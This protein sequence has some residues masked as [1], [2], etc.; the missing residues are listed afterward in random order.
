MSTW[1]TISAEEV[2]SAE[3][4]AQSPALANAGATIEGVLQRIVAGCRES[5][6]SGGNYVDPRPGTIPDQLREEVISIAAWR[7]LM[8]IPKLDALMSKQR[9]SDYDQALAK[10]DMIAS[11]DPKRPRIGAA[12]VSVSTI[13]GQKARAK[14]YG[15]MG[16]T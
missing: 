14:G 16:T 7:S 3:E 13:P 1:R 5:V 9:Q 15:K 12:N 2:F 6:R 8:K 11:N 4:R 10:M